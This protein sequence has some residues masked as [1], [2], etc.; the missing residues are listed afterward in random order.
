MSKNRGNPFVIDQEGKETLDIDILLSFIH[1]QRKIPMPI[2]KK[3]LNLAKNEFLKEKNVVN[4][5]PPVIIL[6][7]IHGQF[8]D[9]ENIIGKFPKLPKS[10]FLFLGDYADRGNFSLETVL[11]LF[12]LKILYPDRII[13]LRG[14]HETRLQTKKY[15]FYDELTNKYKIN[16]E[17]TEIYEAI[18]QCYD[19]LPIA[20]LID[21]EMFC[22]HG[23]ITPDL[24]FVDQLNKIN[25]VEEPADSS[26][27]HDILWSDPHLEYDTFDDPSVTFKFND[28]R[29]C[30][31]YY[32]YRA[33]TEFL[34][35]NN[36]KGIIRAHSCYM[37][38]YHLFKKHESLPNPSI[39]SVFSAPNY[40]PQ[41]QVKDGEEAQPFEKSKGA[42]LYI[43]REKKIK[44]FQFEGVEEPFVLP[45][46]KCILEALIPSFAANTTD[47]YSKLVSISTEA[48]PNSKAQEEKANILKEISEL[49]REVENESSKIM[50]QERKIEYFQP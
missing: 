17:Y 12:S 11:Y 13:M 25:R 8:Y 50:V 43:N 22:V 14:N 21:N 37:K 9:L 20:A 15:D 18:M 3:I 34:K 39:I 28:M 32:T 5:E 30:S 29:N 10:K 49:Y 31:Y 4:I 26:L 42:V 2:V 46:S 19:T 40:I 23:G 35:R 16:N 24:Q 6:G 7:D 1:K 27:L 38:G 33:V 44:V 47:I 48:A 36:L 41:P 45:Y